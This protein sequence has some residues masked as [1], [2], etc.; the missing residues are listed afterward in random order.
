[1]AGRVYYHGSMKP[2]GGTTVPGQHG[3]GPLQELPQA[4]H[5]LAVVPFIFACQVPV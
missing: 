3:V 5:S 2:G 1:M 4:P